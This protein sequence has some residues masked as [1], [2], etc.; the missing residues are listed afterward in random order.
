MLEVDGKLIVA[1]NF[2][3]DNGVFNNWEDIKYIG[4]RAFLSTENRLKYINI[5]SSVETVGKEAFRK[6]VVLKKQYS[7]EIVWNLM[8]VFLNIVI[9]WN[10][11]NFQIF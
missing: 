3:V 8:M 10:M 1:Y 5:P 6:C 4:D 11:L 2:D 9:V 7:M